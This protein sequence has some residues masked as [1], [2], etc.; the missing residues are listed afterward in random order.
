MIDLGFLKGTTIHVIDLETTTNIVSKA[1][2]REFGLAEYVDGVY[3]RGNSGLFSGGISQ[4]GA[5]AVH[6]IS[7]DSV[8]KKVTFASKANVVASTLSGKILMGHNVEKFDLPIIQN[9]MKL[10]NCKIVGSGP[11]GRIQVID[12][13]LA[14]RR[15]LRVPSNRLEDLCIMFGIEHGR[16]RALGDAISCWELFLKIVETT[17]YNDLNQFISLV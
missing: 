11:N 10:Q 14:A 3:V 16:H 8:A 13:L 15:F 2:V 1:F 17:G 5:L 4:P 7:D 6:G 9:V 12:T